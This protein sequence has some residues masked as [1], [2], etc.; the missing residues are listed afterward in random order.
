CRQQQLPVAVV[1]PIDLEKPNNN[2]ESPDL[3][4]AMM[5]DNHTMAQLLEAPTEGY[6]EAIVVPDITANNFEIKHGLLNLV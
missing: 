1:E 6:E 5:A 3:P 2:Q 4:V